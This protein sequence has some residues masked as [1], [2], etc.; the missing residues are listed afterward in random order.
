MASVVVV[1]GCDS[2]FGKDAALKF[3]SLGYHVVAGCLTDDGKAALAKSGRNLVPYALDVTSDEKVR[4]FADKV[5]RVCEGG[6]LAGLVNNAGTVPTGFIEWAPLSD[7]QR[8]MDIN[9]FGQIRLT[10]ALLPLLRKGKG[11]VVNVSSMAGLVALTG[12]GLYACTKF[13][14]EGWTDALRR[15]MS[16]FGVSVHLVEP[17]LFR[18]NMVNADHW[19]K[20]LKKQFAELPDEA[21]E[22]YGE[23][24]LTGHVQ[25]YNDQLEMVADPDTSKVIGAMVSAM[26][27]R[28]PKTRYVV[29]GFARFLFVPISYL[30]TWLA[31]GVLAGMNPTYKPDGKCKPLIMRHDIAGLWGVGFPSA[32]Y[33]FY[34][35]GG[36]YG[37]FLF[38]MLLFITSML[39]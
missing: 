30:P 31:D 22:A 27:D 36:I 4:A 3:E 26:T 7:L 2:G 13:A 28:Y 24:T 19:A 38:M 14:V 32:L 16:P 20:I 8:A 29:G 21:K 9:V 6:V 11:R 39:S 15:E 17:G 1:T 12:V 25:F 33:A 10:K 37:T 35:Y 23:Q 5:A 34:N 18:T